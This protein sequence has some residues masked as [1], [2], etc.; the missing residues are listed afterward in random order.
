[1]NFTN[2]IKTTTGIAAST[3]ASNFAKFSHVTVRYL[4]K[5]YVAYINTE[6]VRKANSSDLK[7]LENVLA[8]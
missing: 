5:S 3:L 4:Q 2:F 6:F 1:M 8:H 7:R